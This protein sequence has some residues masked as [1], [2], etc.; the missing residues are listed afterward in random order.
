L[1]GQHQLAT[2]AFPAI[3]CG[4]YGY[5]IHEACRIALDTTC[6]FLKTNEIIKM[7]SFVLFS[8]GNH[9]VYQEYL[10]KLSGS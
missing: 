1:A 8:S 3:S 2:I 10:A 4:V 9:K 7:V 5:P 6:N